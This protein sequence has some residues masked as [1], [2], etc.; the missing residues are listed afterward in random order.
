MTATIADV[1]K[2]EKKDDATVS[3]RMA[4][5]L[6][7]KARA[8]GVDLVGPGGLLSSLTKQVLETALEAEMDEHLG[9]ERGDQAAKATGNERNGVRS[10]TVQTE[11]GPVAI[12][13]PRDRE[14]SFEPVIVKKRQR[15]LTGVDEIVLS[16]TARGLTSGEISAHLKEVYGSQVSKETISRITDKVID[17][18]AEWQNRPLDRVY[19]VV[20]IDAIHV[21]V[22]DGQVS[23]KP[24][25]AAVGVTVNGERDILGIWAGPGGEGAKYWLNVLTEVKNRGVQDVLIT[26]C[27]GLRGLPDAINAVWEEATVQTC[28]IHLLRNTFKCASRKDWDA[29]SKALRPVYQAPTVEASEE[30]VAG[31]LRGVGQEVPGGGQTLGGGLGGVRAVPGVGRGDPQDHLRHKCH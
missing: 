30:P 19:P 5:E 17:E 22:R 25:Y 26:V 11:I 27:D 7:G 3:R 9:Y 21:K 6:V 13:V 14:S 31:V 8:D 18:M 4:A 16:L 15:R 10:K 12:D 23:N 2:T 1:A 24:F 20:F 28:V 29:I